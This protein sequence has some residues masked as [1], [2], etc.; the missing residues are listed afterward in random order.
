MQRL[1]TGNRFDCN[2]FHGR[3]NPDVTYVSSLVRRPIHLV[4]FSR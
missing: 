1:R 4:V 3:F 2:V